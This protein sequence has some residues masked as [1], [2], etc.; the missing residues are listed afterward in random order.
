MGFKVGEASLEFILCVQKNFN[1]GFVSRHL[2]EGF[3]YAYEL[4]GEYL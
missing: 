1:P 3:C 2:G 4:G